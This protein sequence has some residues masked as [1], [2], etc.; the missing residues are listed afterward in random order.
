VHP[1]TTLLLADIHIAELIRDAAVIGL[2]DAAGHH[3]QTTPATR[4]AAGINPLARLNNLLR[5]V[6]GIRP[7]G[8]AA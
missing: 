6:A 3:R 1:T 8:T 5:K 7:A 2:A 4:R